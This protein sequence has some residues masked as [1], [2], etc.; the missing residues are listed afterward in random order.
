MYKL[1]CLYNVSSRLLQQLNFWSDCTQPFR[2]AQFFRRRAT[3]LQLW[4]SENCEK[5]SHAKL[6]HN[7]HVELLLFSWTYV[8]TPNPSNLHRSKYHWQTSLC[9]LFRLTFRKCT[10]LHVI[11]IVLNLIQLWYR[12]V[13]VWFY[14]KTVWSKLQLCGTGKHTSQMAWHRGLWELRMREWL[15]SFV[16]TVHKVKWIVCGMN[17]LGSV[18]SARGA[19]VRQLFAGI[20]DAVRHLTL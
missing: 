15:P 9:V 2:H 6:K 3:N 7:R 10:G 8:A 11:H 4:T 5:Q 13:I 12:S 14:A 17:N 16:V 19:A 1:T 20:T 18:E